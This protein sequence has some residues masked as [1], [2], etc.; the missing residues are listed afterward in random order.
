MNVTG[1]SS[2]RRRQLLVGAASAAML[3]GAGL[4]PAAR[5]ADVDAA[6]AARSFAEAVAALGG[7]AV[8]S[9]QIVL[10]I[11]ESI[12]SGAVVPVAVT[13]TLPDAREILI[14]VEGNPQ[15]LPVRFAIPDGTEAFVATRIRLAQSSI[16]HVAVRTDARLFTS[17]RSAQVAAGGCS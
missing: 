6:F 9:T 15:P 4:A 3:G 17:S 7:A 11:P 13:T 10:D 14:F 12:D 8:P 1:P 5:A 2:R 16:V